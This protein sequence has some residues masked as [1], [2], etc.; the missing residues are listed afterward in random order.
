MLGGRFRLRVPLMATPRKRWFRVADSVL[1]EDWT[2]DQ[3]ST[4][5]GLL[6]WFNQRRARDG[7]S[8]QATCRASIPPGDLL[9]ITVSDTLEDGRAT[10]FAIRDRFQLRIIERGRFTEVH[11]PNLLNFQEWECPSAGQ[12]P[13][14]RRAA[15]GQ[16]PGQQLPPP[17]R[18]E[19]DPIR[20][21]PNQ[22]SIQEE[23]KIYESSAARPAAE[24]KR[25]RP[26]KSQAP[27]DLDS[28]Q[29][30]A[31]LAWVRAK[32]P[33]HEP[34]IRELVDAC[35]EYHRG[36]G[37]PMADWV[38][39]CQTWIRRS[40][41]MNGNQPNSPAARQDARAQLLADNAAAAM[42]LAEERDQR[43][44]EAKRNRAADA[45]VRRLR[46]NSEPIAH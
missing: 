21:E 36:R 7:V 13:G 38:A 37:T 27:S 23:E 10:L 19:S 24:N 18:S 34:Q 6:A 30:T 25:K 12:A 1:R 35:L 46:T 17:I 31:L 43:E 4:F 39:A 32:Q 26:S 20:S 14:K 28:A 16:T 42:R 44:R 40:R 11:W 5:L 33:T 3:R 8:G 2:R 22:E 45:D 15:A 29:K 9:T 41:T